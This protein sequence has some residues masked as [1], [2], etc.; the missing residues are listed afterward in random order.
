MFQRSL[1]LAEGCVRVNGIK[2]L[3]I[4][5]EICKDLSEKDHNPNPR[6]YY[7]LEECA[8]AVVV[9]A[10]QAR[11]AAEDRYALYS[12]KRPRVGDK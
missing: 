8:E 6:L 12:L 1:I 2:L 10:K 4:H 9:A 3:K 7:D 11:K 5:E